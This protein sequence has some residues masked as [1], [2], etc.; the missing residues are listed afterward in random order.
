MEKWVELQV[1]LQSGRYDNEMRYT[2]FLIRPQ[3]PWVV[4]SLVGLLAFVVF[5]PAVT[6]DFV[7]WDD[8]E[9]VYE[10]QF[11]LGGL[12][13]TGVQRAFTDVVFCNWAPLTILS[14]QLDATLFG[15]EPWG[16]HLTNVL[17]HGFTVAVLYVALVRMTGCPGRSAAATL[18]FAVHPLRVES[19][20]W[21]AERKDVLSVLFLMLSLLAY[22][23]YCR[24]PGVGRYVGVFLAMLAS[25]LCKATLV[26]MPAVLLLL[27]IWPLGRL[28]L[29][30]IGFPGRCDG[31]PGRYSPASV[32]RL[33]LEKL[34]LAALSLS[35][36]IITLLTQQEAMRSTVEKPFLTSR[37]PNALYAIT[38]YVSAFLWPVRLGVAYRHLGAE[39]TWSVVAA[40]GTAV[41]A[42]IAVAGGLRKRFPWIAWGVAWMLVT[43]LP[44][45]GLVQAGEQGYADRFSYVPHVGLTIALVWA[46][47]S[48]CE[49]MGV[50]VRLQCTALVIMT[51]L[52]IAMT[53]RQLT[54]WRNP[55]S[56]WQHAIEIDP[57][58][59]LAHTHVGMQLLAA[60][61]REAAKRHYLAAF[62]ASGGALNVSARLAA[63]HF[64]LGEVERARELRD[65]VIRTAPGDTYTTW[66]V[67]VMRVG[68]PQHMSEESKAMIRRGLVEARGDRMSSALVFF[69]QAVA[70]DPRCA[71]AHNNVGMALLELGRPT[72]AVEAFR[73]AVE[74]NPLHADFQ[75]NLARS[76]HAVN[77]DEEAYRHC[78]AAL[79][80][81][82]TD[83]AIQAFHDGLVGAGTGQ[84]MNHP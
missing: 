21:I 65:M 10:N 69:E 12:S 2:D 67:K 71:D 49:S 79:E 62:Q 36:V 83:A 72:D 68:P 53:E 19:V 14:Y 28:R 15:K 56:L 8:N 55:E 66:V 24:A 5:L 73:R 39:L 31:Q 26:T 25:L 59:F 60:G 30:G 6:Y 33:V 57:D 58:H 3:R 74:I 1:K 75:L 11:V 43:L 52:L 48:I 29:P 44:M 22:E 23:R 7:D 41:L 35:F 82:P 17:F 45:L 54:T 37:V 51:A 13:L 80:A 32:H 18:L 50:S 78:K 38:W 76:L 84:P 40:C 47:T 61:D 70:E 34:P 64:E 77:R 4:A 9:Y 46:I 27:D 16:F 63:L 81:D 42:A 20:A